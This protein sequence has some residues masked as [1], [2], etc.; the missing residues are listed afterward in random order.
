VLATEDYDHLHEHR[1]GI[2]EV[3]DTDR[4]DVAGRSDAEDPQRWMMES[5]VALGARLSISL[6]SRDRL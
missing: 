2:E 5:R 6:S 3:Q 1:L 4:G